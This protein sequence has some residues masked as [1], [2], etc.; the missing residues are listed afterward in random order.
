MSDKVIVSA[1]ITGAINTPTMSPY[2]PITPQQIID[3]AVEAADAGAAVV[4]I[5]VR[6]PKTG[7]PT[8]DL[9]LMEAVY[10]G[11]RARSDV[12]I[13]ITTGGKL[14]SPVEERLAPVPLLR[15]EL[16]SCNA[17]TMNFCAAPVAKKL[18]QPK[19][20]W[21]VSFLSGTYDSFANNTFAS[22]ETYIRT[23]QENGT[24]PEFEVFDIGMLHNL[25]YFISTGLLQCPIYIQFV[26]GV[27]GGIGTGVLNLTRLYQA[28]C[29][30][31][32]K[33]NFSWSVGTAGR[34]QFNMGTAAIL[35][36]GNVRV[37][38][39]DNLY[40]RKGVLAKTNAGQV[41]K[42]RTVIETLDRK[43]ATPDEAREMLQLRGR[44]AAD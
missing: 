24:K 25:H 6:N 14:S 34:E 33:E 10:N 26:M 40:I 16:A 39:E 12:V 13:G 37:G 4:H 15:P 9:Q 11:I 20:D 29:E 1:A 38:L 28:A 30:I 22:M 36:G 21:E 32:G 5:H 7:E 19:F 18:K 3:S 44:N 2:L 35:M 17:G 27:M 43:L 23:M 8:N 41:S 42:M 31:I